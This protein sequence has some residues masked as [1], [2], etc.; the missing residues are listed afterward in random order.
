MGYIVT[1]NDWPMHVFKPLM[2]RLSNLI[3]ATYNRSAGFAYM[4][5]SWLAVLFERTFKHDSKNT[6]VKWALLEFLTL[7][8]TLCPLLKQGN[9]KFLHGAVMK[10]MNESTLYARIQSTDQTDGRGTLSSPVGHAVIG[11]FK[12]CVNALDTDIDKVDFI[13]GLLV[14]MANLGGWGMVP[15][16]YTSQALANIPTCKA[17]N[18]T[19]LKIVREM[20]T[21]GYKTLP[22]HLRGALSYYL[23]E[24]VLNLMNTSQVTLQQFAVIIGTLE[25]LQRGSL[26]WVKLQNWLKANGHEFHRSSDSLS[27]SQTL[28]NDVVNCLSEKENDN[29]GGSIDVGYL[30]TVI[31]LC[32]DAHFSMDSPE[33]G[34]LDGSPDDYPTPLHMI[35]Q[36]MH[37][38]LCKLNSHAYLCSVKAHHTLQLLLA[39]LREIHGSK[40]Q[41]ETFTDQSVMVIVN[42]I[43]TSLEETLAYI[44]RKITMETNNL[45]DV[46]QL[47]VY[48]E[49]IDVLSEL[50]QCGVF[51][52][53]TMYTL[54]RTLDKMSQISLDTLNT[55]TT[56]DKSSECQIPKIIGMNCLYC[57]CSH[58]GRLRDKGGD[59]PSNITKNLTDIR[60]NQRFER[61]VGD[62]EVSKQDLGKLISLFEEKKWN[63]V[64]FLEHN[65]GSSWS[66]ERCVALL[67]E[68]LDVLSI[69]GGT[70]VLPLIDS[71]NMLIKRVIN[72]QPSVCV[73][74][75][76]VTWSMVYD[77]RAD[78]A[79]FWQVI[80]KY[81]DMAFQDCILS[82]PPMTDIYKAVTDI[83]RN[84]FELAEIKSGVLHILIEKY[85]EY[86]LSTTTDTTKD[87]LNHVELLVEACIFGPIQRKDHRV[88]QEALSI[89][90]KNSDGKPASEML[91]S[92]RKPDN[93]VRVLA[94]TTLSLLIQ[95]QPSNLPLLVKKL[96]DSL[97]DK[98]VAVTAMRK[99]YQ[100]NS[101]QHRIKQRIWQ[102]MLI[103][104]PAFDQDASEYML[105]EAMKSLQTDS[106][107]SI[108]NLIEWFI[109]LTLYKYPQF[110]HL[111]WDMFN[112][113][114]QRKTVGVMTS[115]ISIIT[116]LGPVIKCK[117]HQ[118]SSL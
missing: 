81:T 6:V 107:L 48:V 110:L 73:E 63:C 62:M 42:I 26:M 61:P 9:S 60:L 97:L 13:N 24:G 17:W 112:N 80:E 102:T 38:I 15:M 30:A 32:S 92:M 115:L 109:A 44:M 64:F 105:T 114:S 10:T 90:T 58:Y 36:P 40:Q 31:L 103:L 85:C 55:E 95:R 100:L 57:V 106:Q 4:H 94:I 117:Q 68:A 1:V 47:N 84:I 46:I 50:S 76:N 56:Q 20:L 116:I 19:S 82:S 14:A 98:S 70:A 2:P 113:E 118:V 99:Q 83:S 104:Q 111:I 45:T 3:Q 7:D 5:S 41:T 74:C 59:I 108:K 65:Y 72:V 16:I 29:Y 89:L 27:L 67:G 69:V 75:M 28:H 18:W 86:L 91:Q 8:F 101:M 33:K 52:E 71:M 54:Q 49:I 66:V 23:V 79:L 22:N 96:A 37:S 11:Y 51:G 93:H 53:H 39:L 25:T 34:V 21:L 12:S 78:S 88:I 87:I 35:L 43:E 77:I